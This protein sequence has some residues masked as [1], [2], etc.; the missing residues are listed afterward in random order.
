[1]KAKTLA[2]LLLVL[3]TAPSFAQS[4]PSGMFGAP[5]AKLAQLSAEERR[6]L[7]ERWER[8]NPDDRG[9]IRQEVQ[10]RMRMPGFPDTSRFGT[11]YERRTEEG[12]DD[13]RSGREF[14]PGGGRAPRDGQRR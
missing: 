8:A 3:A 10:D 2:T 7:Q 4:V 1:M 14:F 13:E 11:G 9:R 5:V 12:R 6:A